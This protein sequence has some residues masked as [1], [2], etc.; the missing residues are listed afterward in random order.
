MG[1]KNHESDIF[2]NIDS[3]SFG[4]YFK[5]EN[6]LC[7]LSTFLDGFTLSRALS[8]RTCLAFQLQTSPNHGQ[9]YPIRGAFKGDGIQNP[10]NLPHVCSYSYIDAPLQNTTAPG[11]APAR[12]WVGKPAAHACGPGAAWPIHV[13]AGAGDQQAISR[14][15]ASAPLLLPKCVSDNVSLIDV[16]HSVC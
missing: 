7:S 9:S 12:H 16:I 11:R 14:R 1:N 10:E 2:Q 4:H 8:P 13:A 3:T 15:S 6:A 5:L